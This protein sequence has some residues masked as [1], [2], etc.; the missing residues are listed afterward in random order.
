MSFENAYTTRNIIFYTRQ[1]VQNTQTQN[2]NH[3]F[4]QLMEV[5]EVE[6]WNKIYITN[7]IIADT[8]QN[9]ERTVKF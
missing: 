4:N 6:Y 3:A 2:S 9:D 5:C 8:T 7:G 1:N